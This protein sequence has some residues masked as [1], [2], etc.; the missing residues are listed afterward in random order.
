MVNRRGD[1]NV[2]FKEIFEG[3]N[4]AYGIMKLTGE[5]TEKGKAVAK[6][7][8]KREQIADQLWQDHI[9]GKVPP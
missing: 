5:V 9:D 2:K 1:Q 4:S 6:A 7:L 3:N 8:I